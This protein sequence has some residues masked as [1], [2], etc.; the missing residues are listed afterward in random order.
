MLFCAKVQSLNSSFF[1]QKKARKLPNIEYFSL[2]QLGNLFFLVDL[3]PGKDLRES[4]I[5]ESFS[6]GSEGLLAAANRGSRRL[7]GTGTHQRRDEMLGHVVID[8]GRVS[9]QQSVT[10]PHRCDR[11]MVALVDTGFRTLNSFGQDL[12][13]G[14][15]IWTTCSRLL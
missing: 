2:A 9:A 3:L 8:A 1:P 7:V 12:E 15:E 10:G 13:V 11:R 6:L 5:D 4:R 14:N